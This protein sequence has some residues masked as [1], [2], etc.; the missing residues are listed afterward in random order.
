MRKF[1][2]ILLLFPAVHAFSQGKQLFEI[3]FTQGTSEYQGD[4]KPQVSFGGYQNFTE[5]WGKK[6][7]SPY[8]G[9][10]AGISRASLSG[11]DANSNQ[12]W[13]ERRNLSFTNV[14]TRFSFATEF[15]FR[16]YKPQIIGA[17]FTPYLNLG[18]SVVHHSPFAVFQNAEINLRD[19]GTEGQYFL[20]NGSLKPYSRFAVALPI[21][22]GIK[23]SL[24]G[25][26]ALALEVGVTHT[27]TD[28]LDDVSSSYPGRK[29]FEIE[30]QRG[31]VKYSDRSAEIGQA[32]FVSGKQRGV[33]NLNDAYYHA[34]VTLIY[35]I[36]TGKCAAFQR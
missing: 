7:I 32:E 5:I 17:R 35:S 4:L 23:T 6:V 31:A 36:F 9:L 8:F 27:T 13:Q 11:F 22:G 3:G 1:F 21:S 34:G 24:G 25:P 16:A 2:V 12:P 19:Q 29:N 10:K 14:A 26:W 18:L 20:R 30:K 28:Y 15:H 33:A